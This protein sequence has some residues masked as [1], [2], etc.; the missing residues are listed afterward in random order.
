MEASFR[1]AQSDG[2]KGVVLAMHGD[3]GPEPDSEAEPGR[4]VS[5]WL[6]W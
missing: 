2:L 3:P 5:R 4:L 6:L 1:I